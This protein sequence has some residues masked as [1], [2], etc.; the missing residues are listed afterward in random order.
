MDPHLYLVGKLAQVELALE[1]FEA[2]AEDNPRCKEK[3]A[4]LEEIRTKLLETL[5]VL[6]V[7]QTLASHAF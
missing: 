6:E 3:L 1:D 5:V 2:M 7:D 4:S